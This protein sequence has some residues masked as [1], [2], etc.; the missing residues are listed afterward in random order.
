[1][2]LELVLFNV[3]ISDLFHSDTDTNVYEIL[4]PMPSTHLAEAFIQGKLV[5]LQIG[6]RNPSLL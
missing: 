5:K 4:P 1:M 3:H 6:L 2:P